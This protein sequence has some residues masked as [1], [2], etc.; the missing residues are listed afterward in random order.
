[1]KKVQILKRK[2]ARQRASSERMSKSKIPLGLQAYCPTITEFTIVFTK[3]P[4][5]TT[6]GIM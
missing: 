3:I 6:P 1:M 5:S 2:I 4:V